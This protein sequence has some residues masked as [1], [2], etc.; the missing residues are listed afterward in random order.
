[1]KRYSKYLVTATLD[2]LNKYCELDTFYADKPSTALSLYLGGADFWRIY[3]DKYNIFDNV[4]EAQVCKKFFDFNKLEGFSAK[5]HEYIATLSYKGKII[6]KWYA[7]EITNIVIY[8]EEDLKLYHC[9]S[10]SDSTKVVLECPNDVSH[11][12]N[13]VKISED[14]YIYW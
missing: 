6:A 4:P 8:E 5:I 2:N 14:G 7:V 9:D 10:D 3:F 1:M 13:T 12:L 11:A